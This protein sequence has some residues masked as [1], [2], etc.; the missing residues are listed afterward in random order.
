VWRDRHSIVPAVYA[1]L[2]K[3]DN[4][5]LCRR[6]NTGYKDGQYSLP[7]GHLNGGETAIAAACREL[8]EEVGI[9]VSPAQLELAHT[10][11]RMAEEG[12]HERIDLFFEVHEWTGTPTNTEPH[13]CDE[14]RWVRRDQLPENTIDEVNAALQCIDKGMPFSTRGF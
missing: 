1:V 14:L 2:R 6:F 5:L 4:I 12:D 9:K 11:H 7:A 3:D 8:E 10:M 13:K